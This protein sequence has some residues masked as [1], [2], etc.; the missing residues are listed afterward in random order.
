MRPESS[1]WRRKNTRA[2]KES[3][4]VEHNSLLG[5]NDVDGVIREETVVK[6][7]LNGTI[8]EEIKFPSE[9]ETLL[10]SNNEEICLAQ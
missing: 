5:R 3:I 6:G 10:E 7:T 1:F 4:N 2:V 8:T 9:T